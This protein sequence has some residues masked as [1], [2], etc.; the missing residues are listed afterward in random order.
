PDPSKTIR[1]G[2]IAPWNAPSYAHELEELLALA[3]D[4]GLPVDI[5]FSALNDVQRRVIVEGV[6]ERNF[7]GLNG[8]FRWLELRKCKMHLRVCLSRSLK[9]LSCHVCNGERLR[10]EALAVRV[11]NKNLA[12]VCRLKIRD[13]HDYFEKLQLTDW[14]RPIAK[15]LLTDVLSRLKYLIDVGL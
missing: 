8:F 7:G 12:E 6:P 3:D 13:A 15:P 14:R 9:Y 5:P 11:D 4:F 2:A 1:E 10:K